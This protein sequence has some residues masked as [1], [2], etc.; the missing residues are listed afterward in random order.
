MFQGKTTFRLLLLFLF[1]LLYQGM[2]RPVQAG[3]EPPKQPSAPKG[4]NSTAGS[5]GNC[6]RTTEYVVTLLAPDRYVGQ[7]ISSHPSFMWYVLTPQ[8]YPL[9]FRLYKFRDEGTWKLLHKV[10]G[11]SQYGMM[12][13][14]FPLAEKELERSTRYRWEIVLVCDGNYPSRSVVVS[15]EFEVVALPIQLQK[16]LLLKNNIIDRSQLYAQAGFWYDAIGEIAELGDPQVQSLKRSLLV[17]LFDSKKLGIGQI[18]PVE[19]IMN[20]P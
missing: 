8:V 10:E 12:L 9:E 6:S 3:Y 11:K 1:L 16:Q 15:T 2:V 14:R 4:G 19:Q 7:T 20:F 13:Y 5:R 18:I 17:D